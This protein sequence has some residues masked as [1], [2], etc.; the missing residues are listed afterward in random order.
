MKELIEIYTKSKTFNNISEI[1]K[2]V[3]RIRTKVDMTSFE[4]MARYVYEN[5]NGKNILVELQVSTKWCR[6]NDV[7]D[8]IDI[9]LKLRDGEDKDL[10]GSLTI[11]SAI[12]R[13][14]TASYSNKIKIIWLDLLEKDEE[15]LLDYVAE[16]GIEANPESAYTNMVADVRW[17]D[18]VEDSDED[19]RIAS[20]V[21]TWD[22]DE[23]ENS[24]EDD[25]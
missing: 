1:M 21:V 2:E 5:P 18:E 24:K 7:D 3:N 13:Y 16:E 25:E 12:H 10:V 23:D 6:D 19:S 11:A 14:M 4:E 8:S 9:V 20:S 17:V 15:S 22:E